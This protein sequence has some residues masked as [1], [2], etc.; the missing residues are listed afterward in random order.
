MRF[1]VMGGTGFVGTALL[2]HLV[3]AGHEVAALVRSAAGEKTLP[4][5]VAAVAG[6]PL[7]PGGWQEPAAAADVLVNLVGRPI[8]ARWTPTVRREI[9]E[10]RVRSTRMAVAALARRAPGAGGT[11]INANAVGWYRGG[12]DEILAEDAPPGDGFLAEVARSWQA[13]AEK[14]RD[15]G[16]R[17]VVTRFGTVLGPGGGALDRLL[18][19]F[20]FGLGGRLGSGRQ[21]FSWIHVA[22]LARAVTFLA[23]RK[24]LEGPVNLAAPNPVRNAEF[25]RALARVLHRP[26][27]LPVPAP[28][29]RL[30]LGEV[31]EV[32]LRGERVVP[33]RLLEA[34]FE[35]RFPTVEAALRDILGG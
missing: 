2:C 6:N 4:P 31:A 35:F 10:T 32:I 28:L 21:W 11:L 26:A 15:H 23:E 29:L 20:R 7:E 3:Q 33:K 18:P 24:D 16:T 22:D 9:L 17:V 25:T 13:E 34:G 30:L 1:F 5:G 27:L 19:P 14:A 8:F 12:S